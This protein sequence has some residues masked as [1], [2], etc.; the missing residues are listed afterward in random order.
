MGTSSSCRK[1]RR[2]QTTMTTLSCLLLLASMASLASP[3]SLK[4]LLQPRLSCDS[5]ACSDSILD[6]VETCQGTGSAEE[7]T[8][9]VKNILDSVGQGDCKACICHTVPHF[10]QEE[11][12]DETSGC[13]DD[14]ISCGSACCIYYEWCCPGDCCDVTQYN[15][16]VEC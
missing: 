12:V 16:E 15:C 7:V 9:R 1:S 13:N 4:E 11:K 8:G 3:M 2:N 6:A 10:C 14:E 5:L